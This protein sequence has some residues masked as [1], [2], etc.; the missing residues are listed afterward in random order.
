VI[1]SEESNKEIQMP[2][3]ERITDCR[4]LPVLDEK[5]VDIQHPYT[6][7]SLG[8]AVAWAINNAQLFGRTKPSTLIEVRDYCLKIQSRMDHQWLTGYAVLD[9]LDAAI[10]GRDL[11]SNSRI[12]GN[13]ENGATV[14]RLK[15]SK[16]EIVHADSESSH[17]L[18]VM[19]WMFLCSG[20]GDSRLTGGVWLY[21]G[22]KAEAQAMQEARWKQIKQQNDSY[23]AQQHV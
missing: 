20:H 7:Y 9:V 2:I 4:K 17:F 21:Q 6:K 8:E 3:I 14:R 19:G 18:Q 5:Y 16:T 15:F 23:Y 11:K 12:L 1:E 13:I 22:D 10:D